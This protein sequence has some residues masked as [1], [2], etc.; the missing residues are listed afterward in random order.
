MGGETVWVRV[1]DET[2]RELGIESGQSIDVLIKSHSL[3]VRTL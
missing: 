1:T 3:N 2:I